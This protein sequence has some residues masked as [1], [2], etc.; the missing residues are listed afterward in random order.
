MHWKVLHDWLSEL[1]GNI[2]VVG[3]LRDGVNRGKVIE[4]LQVRLRAKTSLVSRQVSRGFKLT[5]RDLGYGQDWK[6]YLNEQGY[7]HFEELLIY[8]PKDW[9][10]QAREYFYRHNWDL[11]RKSDNSELRV[12][13][14]R[15]TTNDGSEHTVS[16]TMNSP[17]LVVFFHPEMK[18]TSRYEPLNFLLAHGVRA[19]LPL[20]SRIWALYLKV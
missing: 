2:H 9:R 20:C 7:T 19:P 18:Q 16:I 11:D 8:Q 1:N 5:G 12:V 17:I 13:E 4:E 6:E 3:A 15:L 14:K 10:K